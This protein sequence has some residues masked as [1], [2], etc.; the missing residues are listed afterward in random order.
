MHKIVKKIALIVLKGIYIIIFLILFKVGWREYFKIS[1]LIWFPAWYKWVSP[2]T[3][4][5]IHNVR[6]T[7]KFKS[8]MNH[9]TAC[10]LWK[11]SLNELYSTRLVF[12]FICI[13]IWFFVKTII[14][15]IL[16]MLFFYCE[17]D[18]YTSSHQENKSLLITYICHG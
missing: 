3:Y 2:H 17:P 13:V 14:K 11:D 6:I 10:Q 5:T 9:M 4:C 18:S 8:F 1:F 12:A 15:Y 16:R 7:F